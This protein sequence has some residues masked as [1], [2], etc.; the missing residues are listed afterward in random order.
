MTKP[1][2]P[3]RKAAEYRERDLAVLRNAYRYGIVMN[4]TVSAAILAG[5]EAGHVLR[6]FGDRNWLSMHSAAIPG[7]VSYGTLTAQGGKEIGVQLKPKP[8]GAVALDTALAVAYYC[9]VAG[10][11]VRRYRLL[12]AEVRKIAAAL[13]V[14]VPHV[15]TEEL[16]EPV[17]LRVQQAATGKMSAV[18]T[19]ALSTLEKLAAETSCASLIRSRLLGLVVLGHTPERVNQLQKAVNSDSLL[20]DYRVVV[21]LGPTAETLAKCLRAGKKGK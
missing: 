16:A 7:G 15:V 5:K 1:P 13:P 18:R 6:R 17:V 20:S 11:T 2:P 21:G 12:G 9:T 8:L 10:G 19:K 3:R 4:A 14:N